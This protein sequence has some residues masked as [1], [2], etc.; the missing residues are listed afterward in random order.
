MNNY[1]LNHSEIEVAM[2]EDMLDSIDTVHG[3][4]SYNPA[5]PMS[6]Y[7]VILDLPEGVVQSDSKDLI[8]SMPDPK[9]P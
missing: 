2:R 4:V 1:E 5:H 6:A 7:P 8:V 9:N 3:T